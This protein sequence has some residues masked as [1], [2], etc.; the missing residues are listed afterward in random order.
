MVNVLGKGKKKEE[1]LEELEYG[2]GWKGKMRELYN[3]GRREGEGERSRW[4]ARTWSR[5]EICP[6]KQTAILIRG[7]I[8]CLSHKER[9][10]LMERVSKW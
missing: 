9:E 1:D 4:K 5:K 2:G 10:T 3:I 8:A 6:S 7:M